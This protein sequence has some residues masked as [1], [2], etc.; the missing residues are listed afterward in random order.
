MWAAEVPNQKAAIRSE[1]NAAKR[2]KTSAD[3]GMGRLG[4]GDVQ[5]GGGSRGL[6]GKNARC[7]V[8][9]HAVR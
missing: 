1:R 4:I 9:Q 2:M 5:G 8:P 3:R 7:N 6:E